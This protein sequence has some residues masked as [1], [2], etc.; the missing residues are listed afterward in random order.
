M[1]LLDVTVIVSVSTGSM[2]DMWLP[3]LLRTIR[4]RGQSYVKQRSAAVL[5]VLRPRLELAEGRAVGRRIAPVAVV[6]LRRDAEQLGGLVVVARHLGVDL[7]PGERLVGVLG[8][9]LLGNRG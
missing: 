7:V 3:L 9:V 4:P 6:I 1:R 8:G 2:V 5:G